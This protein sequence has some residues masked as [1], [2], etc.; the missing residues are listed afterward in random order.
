MSKYRNQSRREQ[1]LFHLRFSEPDGASVIQKTAGGVRQPLL[2]ERVWI[3][4][5]GLWFI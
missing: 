5:D 2:R 3:S 4:S 1:F